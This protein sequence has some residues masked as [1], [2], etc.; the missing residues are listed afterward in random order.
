M[1]TLAG[2]LYAVVFSQG[3]H[4]HQLAGITE[5]QR[6]KMPEEHREATEETLNQD[7]HDGIDFISM[8]TFKVID[9]DYHEDHTPVI[10]GVIYR[11]GDEHRL[12]LI[13]GTKKKRK[14]G[15]H[16]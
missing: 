8:L 7:I 4:A 13:E 14:P 6:R 11:E 2:M 5:E 15:D 3:P 16:P 12:W 1:L 10:K 9:G